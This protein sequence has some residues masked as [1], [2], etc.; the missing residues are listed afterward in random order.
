MLMGASLGSSLV[1]LVVGYSM[2][3][4]GPDVLTVFVLALGLGMGAAYTCTHRS[5][6]NAAILRRESSQASP[7]SGVSLGL[8]NKVST[9]KFSSSPQSSRV[10]SSEKSS[11]EYK[12]I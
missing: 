11:Y 2:K 6:T 5:L 10:E 1:P 12:S 7:G 8:V 4:Y 9:G 3:I